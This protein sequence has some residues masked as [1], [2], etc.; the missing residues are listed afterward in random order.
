M[1][2][3]IPFGKLVALI[4]QVC[5]LLRSALKMFWSI[6]NNFSD[7]VSRLHVQIRLMGNC[8]LNSGYPWLSNTDGARCFSCKESIEGVSHF[9][10]DCS[11][12]KDNFESVWTNLNRK[13]MSSVSI[14]LAP[15]AN[16]INSLDSQH[17]PLLFLKFTAYS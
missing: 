17:Y 1:K 15:M 13:I 14:D 2:K 3:R 5:K 16:F 8:G 6:A 9:F 10:F 11:K 7:L 4:T 12:F